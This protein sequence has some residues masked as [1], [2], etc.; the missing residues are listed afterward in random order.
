MLNKFRKKE[1]IFNDLFSGEYQIKEEISP[2]LFY[3]IGKYNFLKKF[4]YKME[5]L[6]YLMI[7]I[8]KILFY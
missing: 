6:L 1:M 7:I 2:Q 8:I 5:N 3:L 4:L